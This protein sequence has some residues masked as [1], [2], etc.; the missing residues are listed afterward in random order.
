MSLVLALGSNID[1]PLKN[2][3]MARN[4]L[5]VYF[6]E[7]KASRIYH[8]KAIEYLDQPSFLNQVIEYKTPKVSAKEVFVIT[9]SIERK[10]LRKKVINKGPR[11]IDIDI[12]FYGDLKLESKGLTIPHKSWRD[13]S[14]VL[15][16]L[17]ELPIYYSLE[18]TMLKNFDFRKL[19]ACEI[20]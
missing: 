2:L 8:S 18:K 19:E 5:Q 7:I 11:N 14:F 13:R 12:I 4:F 10:M 3:R 17:R 16:P 1:E 6:E 9:Q 20:Y 15:L